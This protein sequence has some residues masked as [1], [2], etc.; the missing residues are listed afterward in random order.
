MIACVELSGNVEMAPP[1]N[2]RDRSDYTKRLSLE[3]DA[4]VSRNHFPTTPFKDISFYDP[5]Q[6]QTTI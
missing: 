6:L 5:S 2:S 4:L 3:V 1:L